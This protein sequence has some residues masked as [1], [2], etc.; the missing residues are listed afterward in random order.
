MFL[1]CW[2]KFMFEGDG[3]FV[4]L[5]LLVCGLLVENVWSPRETRS[6]VRTRRENI[7][8]LI[9]KILVSDVCRE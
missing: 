8:K 5:S 1:T 9:Y 3:G 7:Q 4:I 6:N 2:V